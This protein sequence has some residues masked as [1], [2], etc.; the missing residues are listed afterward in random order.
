MVDTV[1]SRD[2]NWVRWKAENCPSISRNPVSYQTQIETQ[3]NLSKQILAKRSLALPAGASDLEFLNTT[4]SMEDLIEVGRE[5]TSRIPTMKQ[6]HDGI[7]SDE[8][9]A[10]MGT[11]EEIEEAKEGGTSKLWRALR[12]SG[13]R[14]DLCER[15]ESGKK[16]GALV[17]DGL[18]QTDQTVTK[19]LNGGDSH[20]DEDT[21]KEHES[22][23]DQDEAGDAS[24]GGNRDGDA[25]DP[26]GDI[27]AD[28]VV[29][30]VPSEVET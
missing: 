19:G 24:E 9:N 30:I 16:L 11:P 21:G 17:D 13:R 12:A 10:E 26:P 7:Q 29:D 5:K 14:Y 2:K 22:L 4:S 20:T 1:L 28:V 23:Q 3:K 25:D 15:I 18:R 8:L 27:V 6:F